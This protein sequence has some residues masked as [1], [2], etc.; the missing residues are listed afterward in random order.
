MQK[1]IKFQMK[2]SLVFLTIIITFVSC[3]IFVEDEFGNVIGAWAHPSLPGY[4]SK[5]L[6]PDIPQ[7]SWEISAIFNKNLTGSIDKKSTQNDYETD[8]FTYN[9]KGDKLTITFDQESVNNWYEI[10]GVN[11]YVIAKDTLVITSDDNTI[12]KL[13]RK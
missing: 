7:T 1:I 5:K 12:T 8:G 10:S 13:V 4:E 9:V 11:T 6:H 2:K 3:S